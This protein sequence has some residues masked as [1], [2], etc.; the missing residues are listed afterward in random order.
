MLMNPT[1]GHGKLPLALFFHFHS[2]RI[3]ARQ[4]NLVS[5]MTCGLRLFFPDTAKRYYQHSEL[6]KRNRQSDCSRHVLFGFLRLDN[7]YHTG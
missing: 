2:L 6:R 3:L 7:E 4:Y 1:Y 5:P